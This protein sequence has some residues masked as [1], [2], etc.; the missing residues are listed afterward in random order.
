ML[1]HLV[2]AADA[3]ATGDTGDLAPFDAFGVGSA[4]GDEGAQAV[5]A[6]RF[7]GEDSA[8]AQSADVLRAMFEDGTSV[9][10][11]EPRSE[12][13]RV[14]DVEVDGHVV[15]VTLDVPDSRSPGVTFQAIFVHEPFTVST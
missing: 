15:V 11:W 6:Y 3:T 10:T 13:A 5:L 1:R 7:A 2:P 9:Q 14:D 12:R 8:S 4:H